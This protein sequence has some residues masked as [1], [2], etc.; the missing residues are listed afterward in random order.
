[1]IHYGDTHSL[2]ER[3]AKYK[4]PQTLTKRS[5]ELETLQLINRF[6]RERNLFF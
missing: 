3:N 1:M 6:S 5:K 4:Q 2:I